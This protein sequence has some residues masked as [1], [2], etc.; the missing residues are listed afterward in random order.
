MS[1][2]GQFRGD[3]RAL[4]PYLLE[5]YLSGGGRGSN[6]PFYG[7]PPP[8]LQ[9]VPM[10][11]GTVVDPFWLPA[12]EPRMMIRT[13][14][15]I[16]G[17]SPAATE[18]PQSFSPM[19]LELSLL[20]DALRPY[21]STLALPPTMPGTL[22]PPSRAAG[23]SKLTEEEQNRAISKLRKEAYTPPAPPLGS[24]LCLYY[25]DRFADAVTAGNSKSE[26]GGKRCAICLED[27]EAKEEVM[28]TPCDHMFHE[29]CIV[30]WVKA[31]G[32]CPVCRCSISDRR[33]SDFHGRA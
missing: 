27:F 18:S 17:I 6:R 21:T 29:D 24:R 30:P 12:A 23:G 20:N 5:P 28:L 3:W 19:G 10:T 9:L 16:S 1:H 11:R 25:R 15:V 26:E 4:P 33:R 13:R 22:N 14:R 31:N 2:G 32:N 7:P 8:N